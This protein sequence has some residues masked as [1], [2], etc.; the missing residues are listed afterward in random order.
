MYHSSSLSCLFSLSYLSEWRDRS[1]GLEHWNF[2]WS[3]KGTP[4]LKNLSKNCK[5]IYCKRNPWEELHSNQYQKRI[6]E[7]TNKRLSW[8][9]VDAWRFCSCWSF[10]SPSTPCRPPSHREE[11]WEGTDNCEEEKY[12][13]LFVLSWRNR[14]DQLFK[15]YFFS[16]FVIINFSSGNT[17][18]PFQI[19]IL[20][21]NTFPVIPNMIYLANFHQ[22]L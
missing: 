1:T 18:K 5:E 12:S 15:T 17:R 3:T 10:S 2:L 11:W 21:L 8:A 14:S 4:L 22:I 9:S 13:I 7:S 19:Q 20:R 16:L 6:D